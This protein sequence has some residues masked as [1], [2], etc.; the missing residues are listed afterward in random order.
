[1][2]HGGRS[3]NGRSGRTVRRFLLPVSEWRRISVAQVKKI[4]LW[5]SPDER[6]YGIFEGA[7]M[8][9][10]PDGSIQSRWIQQVKVVR[11][12]EL[13][14]WTQDFGPAEDFERVTPLIMPSM[15]DDTVGLL[16][17]YAEKNRHDD[18]WARRRDEMLAS[19][20]LIV[21]HIAKLE[22]ERELLHNRSVLGPGINVQRNDVPAEAINRFKKEKRNGARSRRARP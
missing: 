8:V 16:Q 18:Y 5:V 4:A 7:M 2:R 1:M 13:H 9:P 20:T 22:R 14:Y 3:A 11:G 15:G 21:D 17:A 19:S 12:D 10:Q 6:C